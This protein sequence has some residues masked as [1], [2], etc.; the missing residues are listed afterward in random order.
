[1]DIGATLRDAR[2]RHGLSLESV[3]VKTKIRVDQ[4]RALEDNAF[5]RLPAGIF[6]RGSIRA[7]AREVGL[8]SEQIVSS[9]RAEFGEN[10]HVRRPFRPP[11]AR[12]LPRRP[13]HRWTSGLR[14]TRS[15]PFRSDRG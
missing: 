7:Y 13:A 4:L 2:E 3:S 8:D 5:E 12:R 9:Y 6:A 15:S 1:M 11:R 10:R 14:R